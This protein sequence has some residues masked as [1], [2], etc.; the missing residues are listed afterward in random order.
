MALLIGQA[1]VVPDI[2]IG[3]DP[4]LGEEGRVKFTGGGCAS[5]S[6]TTL[7][8]GSTQPLTLE[9]Q[10]DVTLPGDLSV[11]STAPTVIA[12][13]TGSS[14][15]EVVLEAQRAGDAVVELRSAGEVWDQLGFRAEPAASV[16][17]DAPD[18]VFAGGTASLQITEVHGACG[19]D[20]PL[21]GEGFVQWS[22]EP[23]AGLVLQRDV[24]GVAWFTAGAAGNVHLLGHEPSAGGL[25]V[26]HTLAIVPTADAGALEA[27]IIVM[28]PDQTVL[29][30]QPLPTEVPVG[31]LVLVELQATAGTLTVPINGRDV[32]WTIEGDAGTLEPYV[33]GDPPSPAGSIFSTVAAGTVTLVADV[34][35]LGRTARFAMTVT[36]TP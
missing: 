27:G 22:A 6:T 25:L 16:K 10:G 33:S 31:S 5:S 3:G 2:N 9:P 35:L 13:R 7:A 15:D 26:A 32:T 19:D 14:V 1:C 17:Y 11:G 4:R 24:D 8:V 20:C 12:A 28:L 18:A 21:L 29:D 23:A 30:L 36:D 34:P